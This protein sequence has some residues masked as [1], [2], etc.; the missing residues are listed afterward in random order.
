MP[1]EAQGLEPWPALRRAAVAL[2]RLASDVVF[3]RRCLTCEAVIPD[4]PNT[5]ICIECA[6]RVEL[7]EEPFCAVCGRPFWT[8]GGSFVSPEALCGLCRTQPPSFVKARAVGLYR[9]YLKELILRMKYRPAA[10]GA[11]ALAGLLADAYPGLFGGLEP[12]AV[13]PVPLH[14]GRFLEREFDQAH[15]MAAE[16]TRA[17][18]W[19]LRRWLWRTRDTPRQSRLSRAGRRLNV[20]GAFAASRRASLGGRTVLLVDDV[21]TTGATV[22]E[23][24]RVLAKAGAKS[25]VVYTAARVE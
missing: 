5:F 18:G 17:T 24:A 23:A 3:P 15:L 12:D 2:G 25:V 6:G 1:G 16:L 11:Y 13:V 19:P 8:F 4:R 9:G 22:R 7:V 20:R 14:T 21:M 10:K